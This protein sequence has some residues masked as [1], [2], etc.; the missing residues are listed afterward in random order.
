MKVQPTFYIPIPQDEQW[1]TGVPLCVI[2][3]EPIFGML[4]VQ[5]APENFGS[6]SVPKRKWIKCPGPVRP[7]KFAEYVMLYHVLKPK[8]PLP[9]R[10]KAYIPF[11]K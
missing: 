10:A 11:Q 7:L 4:Q 2:E 3:G 5:N 6:K 9:E 8:H 1:N